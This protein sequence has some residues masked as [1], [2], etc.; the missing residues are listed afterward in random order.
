MQTLEILIVSVVSAKT[1]PIRYFSQ[2]GCDKYVE[3]K[4]AQLY[5][6][7][8][9]TVVFNLGKLYPLKASQPH[10]NSTQ[11][12]MPKV[13]ERETLFSITNLRA[14]MVLP[15]LVRTKVTHKLF[16]LGL[17]QFQFKSSCLITSQ[18]SQVPNFRQNQS[19]FSKKISVMLATTYTIKIARKCRW[20]MI[21][22][23]IR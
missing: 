3:A 11:S 10:G 4:S 18:V 7:F 22:W 1:I 19:G 16:L 2:T 20:I 9:N 12:W 5:G 6:R 23:I 17:T 15:S 14:S 13:N 21:V 8:Q